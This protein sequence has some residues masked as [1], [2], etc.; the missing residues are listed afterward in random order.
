[1]GIVQF[2][3]KAVREWN[4][5]ISRMVNTSIGTNNWLSG[6]KDLQLPKEALGLGLDSI[7]NAQAIAI[8]SGIVNFGINSSDQLAKH[9]VTARMNSKDEKNGIRG[10][11][12]RALGKVK[13]EIV[14][15]DKKMRRDS[16][17]PWVS[18]AMW[19][20][21][22]DIERTEVKDFFGGNSFIS[23][24]TFERR[25]P[26]DHKF[27]E[28]WFAE[29]RKAANNKWVRNLMLDIKNGRNSIG[30]EDLHLL[31][32]HYRLGISFTSVPVSAIVTCTVAYIESGSTGARDILIWDPEMNH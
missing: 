20:R 30:T 18:E 28:H 25:L 19:K 14:P 5:R 6:W 15:I 32:K 9:S 12:K 17:K 2:S 29:I 1:M 13:F 22:V 31:S 24:E 21:L 7:E 27:K 8:V 23:W 4:K 16:M 10:D 3:E 11:L 26:Q